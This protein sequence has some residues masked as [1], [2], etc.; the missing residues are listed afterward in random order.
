MTKMLLSALAAVLLP[1]CALT[2]EIE[3]LE[4][5]IACSA[6]KDELYVVSKYGRVAIA[7][8]I[9]AKDREVICK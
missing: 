6:A 8:V 2:K 4:N 3:G 9:S 5:R 7:S 1:G